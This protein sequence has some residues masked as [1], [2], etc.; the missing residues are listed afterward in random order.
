MLEQ[1]MHDFHVAGS[2]RAKKRRLPREIH[3]GHRT[4]HDHEI[5]PLVRELARARVRVRALFQ[6]PLDQSK[7]FVADIAVVARSS[8]LEVAHVDRRPERRLPVPVHRIHVGTGVEQQ[9]RDLQMIALARP[10]DAKDARVDDRV[11]QRR[12]AVAIGEL[13]TR[14]AL[15]QKPRDFEMARSRGIQKRRLRAAGGKALAPSLRPARAN[16]SC[17]A[18][19]ALGRLARRDEARRLFGRGLRVHVGAGIDEQLRELEVSVSGRNHQRRLAEMLLRGVDGGAVLEQR[20]RDRGIA[21]VRREN[22]RRLTGAIGR[23]GIRTGV[24]QPARQLRVARRNCQVQRRDA[25]AIRGVHVGAR[26]DESLRRVAVPDA[27]G[28]MQRG[29]A[30]AARR[31]DVDVSRVEQ[32]AHSLH[33]AAHARRRRAA[34][35]ARFRPTARAV[36]PEALP[37]FPTARA[38]LP[39]QRSCGRREE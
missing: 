24:E 19:Q 23:G 14:A 4:D 22:Q 10:I 32:R 15:D 5:A 37:R 13:E 3:P 18:R 9:V 36:L 38:A 16:D 27:H 20:L 26:R 34:S 35:S 31:V 2:G 17:A 33:V 11:D 8:E 30:V 12:D 28:P 1:Q 6:Q 21:D 39:E 7:R 29:R 25:I